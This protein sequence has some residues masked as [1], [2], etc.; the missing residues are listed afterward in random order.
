VILDL[1]GGFAIIALILWLIALA[2]SI[3][4]D[5][6]LIRNLPKV[7]WIILILIIFPIGAILW[8]ILGRPLRA[9]RN[10][11]YKGSSGTAPRPRRGPSA[12]DD[13][14]QFLNSLRPDKLQSWED[15]LLRRE[16]ELKDRKDPESGD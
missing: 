13:D 16:R 9:S 8:F 10:L 12:P 5:E 3:T 15:D 6:S 2:E 7:L 4:A 11:P 14:P 1:E